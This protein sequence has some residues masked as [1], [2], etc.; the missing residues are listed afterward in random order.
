MLIDLATA[1]F[2]A[3]MGNARWLCRAASRVCLA[4]SLLAGACV[5]IGGGRGARVRATRAVGP[6]HWSSLPG[7]VLMIPAVRWRMPGLLGVV[8]LRRAG[9]QSPG[10][11]GGRLIAA[12]HASAAARASTSALTSRTGTGRRSVSDLRTASM[13]LKVSMPS[14]SSG[15]QG[16]PSS[17]AAANAS[18]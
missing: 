18:A 8:L 6:R 3:A 5:G 11:A 9:E 1:A 14:S 15:A 13:T 12:A 4:V 7:L 16:R 10:Q 17:N 2:A